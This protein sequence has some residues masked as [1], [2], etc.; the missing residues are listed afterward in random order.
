MTIKA[1]ALKEKIEKALGAVGT[2][3]RDYLK[4]INTIRGDYYDV[5]Q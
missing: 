5:V 2:S 4:Q 1:R 3:R